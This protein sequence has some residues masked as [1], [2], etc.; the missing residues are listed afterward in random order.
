LREYINASSRL[1]TDELQ[2][3]ALGVMNKDVLERAR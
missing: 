1:R 3:W 2:A